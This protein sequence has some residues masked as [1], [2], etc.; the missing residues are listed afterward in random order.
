M[1]SGVEYEPTPTYVEMYEMYKINE[2]SGLIINKPN[3]I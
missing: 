3:D 2:I 1:V